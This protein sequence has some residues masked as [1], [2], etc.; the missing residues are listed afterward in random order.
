MTVNDKPEPE[1][2]PEVWIASITG[3]LLENLIQV[4]VSL[5]SI[6]SVGVYVRITRPNFCYGY[7]PNIVQTFAPQTHKVI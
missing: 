3:I 7:F 4:E 1:P 6:V 5:A 2:E